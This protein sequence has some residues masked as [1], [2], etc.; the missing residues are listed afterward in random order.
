MVSL[1]AYVCGVCRAIEESLASARAAASPPRAGPGEVME[2]EVMEGEV[3]E[4]SDDDEELRAVL[5]L[6]AI[7]HEARQSQLVDE[8]RALS[9]AL[10]LSL[11][12]E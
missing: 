12:D 6:S 9:E 3:R 11:L 7:E 1:D 2:G 8:Q 4:Q 10:R 5:A